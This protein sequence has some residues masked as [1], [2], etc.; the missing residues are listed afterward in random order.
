MEQVLSRNLNIVELE[1]A[2]LAELVRV[3]FKRHNDPP[4]IEPLLESVP[5][6]TQLLD[7]LEHCGLVLDEI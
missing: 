4:A 2:E 7:V 1:E 3:L 6:S 5:P